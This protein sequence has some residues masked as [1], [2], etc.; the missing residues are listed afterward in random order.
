M[1]EDRVPDTAPIIHTLAGGATLLHLSPHTFRFSDGTIAEPQH[2]DIC[3]FFTLAR[4]ET[5]KST[6]KGMVCN[7]TRFL[8]HGNQLDYLT[9]LSKKADIV[10]VPLPMLLTLREQGQRK[11][12][13]N[14][15]AGNSTTETQ[16]SAPDQKIYDVQ[17]WSW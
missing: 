8:L 16:R 5:R 3:Q 12:Y 7:E 6:I 14:V 11:N 15:V 1:H 9:E 17:N 4:H 10:L 13:T 2:P